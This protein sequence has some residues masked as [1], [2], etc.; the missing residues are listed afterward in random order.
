MSFPTPRSRLIYR[1][2]ILTSLVALLIMPISAW[3]ICGPGDCKYRKE[4]VFCKTC[5]LNWANCKESGP[6]SCTSCGLL[7]C[8]TPFTGGGDTESSQTYNKSW[9]DAVPDYG[10]VSEEW[11][12]E[13]CQDPNS[14]KTLQPIAI[15]SPTDALD[16][17]QPYG[18]SISNETLKELAEISTAAAY[19]VGV[20][21]YRGGGLMPPQNLH[22]GERT[23]PAII[24]N[25]SN[26]DEANGDSTK[27]DIEYGE[28]PEGTQK[29][30]THRDNFAGMGNPTIAVESY[31]MVLGDPP[32]Q[33]HKRITLTLSSIPVYEGLVSLSDNYLAPVYEV[34]S[35][36]VEML[37][38]D[39]QKISTVPI[40]RSDY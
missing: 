21:M 34:E 36:T 3:S 15:W 6:Y 39:T 19:L 22:S 12:L 9:K 40:E 13:D 25:I 8:L 32:I 33:D 4:G 11:M 23:S 16:V 38:P 24:T 2:L 5:N 10:Y 17:L 1:V 37:S 18:L 29:F 20:R 31:L 7:I 26:I 35:F 28:L 27:W 30:V 14:T